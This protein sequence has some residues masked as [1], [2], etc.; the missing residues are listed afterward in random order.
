[1]GRYGVRTWLLAGLTCVLRAL[2]ILIVPDSD[3]PPAAASPADPQVSATV[4][5]QPTGAKLP[6]GF[7]GV[8]PE[9]SA[10]HI[11]PRRHPRAVHP[12][13]SRLPRNRVAPGG[14]PVLPTPGTPHRRA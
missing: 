12:V 9:D 4:G 8:S 13:L 7:T 5:S 10:L 11:Y 1:M 3:A 2:T 14:S 6:S